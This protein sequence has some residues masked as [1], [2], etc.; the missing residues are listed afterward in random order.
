MFFLCL[1]LAAVSPAQDNASRGSGSIVRSDGRPSQSDD[2]ALAVLQKHLL[3]RG[4]TNDPDLALR[5][6]TAV[7]SIKLEGTI[8]ERGHLSQAVSYRM[9]PNFYRL[10]RKRKNLDWEIVSIMATEG[11]GAVWSQEIAKKPDPVRKVEGNESAMFLR[12]STFLL[13][14]VDYKTNGVYWQYRGEVKAGGR[15]TFLIKG[16]FPSG[17]ERYYYF[18]QEKYFLVCIGQKDELSGGIIEVDIFPTKIEKIGGIMFETAWVYRD[19]G[20]A[21]KTITWN[22]VSLNPSLDP[23]IFKTPVEK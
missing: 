7:T 9:A 1:F 22:K 5:K 21:Y 20:Q 16:S 4:D 23:A 12:D 10:E 18:D 14:L 15:R 3:F 13:P 2:K 6:L 11:N 19:R 17:E 8:E